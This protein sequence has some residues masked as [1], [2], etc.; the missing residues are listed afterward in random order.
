MRKAKQYVAGLEAGNN[1]EV[2]EVHFD[3]KENSVMAGESGW[4]ESKLSNVRGALT[5]V[6]LLGRR[7]RS[8]QEAGC[9][10]S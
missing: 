1:L 4:F 6:S 10:G 8:R 5:Q 3:E 9:S 2:S 7:Y